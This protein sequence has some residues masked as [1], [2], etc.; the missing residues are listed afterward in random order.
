MTLGEF[1]ARLEGVKRSGNGRYMALCPAHDD[2]E[3]SLSIAEKDGKVLL[4]CHAGCRTEDVLKAL[5]LTMGDLFTDE[6]ARPKREERRIVAVYRYTDAK[7]KPFEV[8]KTDPKGFYQRQPDGKGGYV[9]N[10]KG[11][12]PTLYHQDELPQAIAN[13][14]IIFKMEG[15]EDVDNGRSRL[16]LAATTNPMGAGKWRDSYTQALKGGDL[17]IIP[18]KDGRGRE[19]AAKV[20]RS[21]YGVAKRVRTLELPDRDGYKVKDMSDWLAA[22]GTREELERLVGQVPDYRP[23]QLEEILSR[24]RE[25]YYMPDVGPVEIV[26]GNVAANLHEGDPVWLLLVAPPG[27]G[28]TEATNLLIG[29]EHVHAVAVLT[30]ASLLSGTPRRQSV[31]AKGGLL[32]ELDDFGI[33]VVKDFGGI[34]SL[35]RDARGPILAA[36]REVYDGSWTRYVGSDGGRTLHW[37]GKVG[38]VGGATPSIDQHYAVMAALGERFLYYRL[39]ET[40]EGQKAQAALDHAGH[41]AE[42]RRD[43]ARMVADFF[44]NLRLSPPEPLSNKEQDKLIALALF[45]TRC[46]SAVERDSWASREIQLVPGTESPTRLVKCL[47]QLLNGLLA[48]GVS[49]KRAWEL[50]P[51]VALDSIPRSGTASLRR[52]WRATAIPLLRT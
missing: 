4:H 46:R 31:G 17:V 32:R 26:R 52:C 44:A 6:A 23:A 40:D 8:V 20:A 41:E 51:K 19:H 48:I 39:P 11:I 43:L 21:C 16:G 14:R 36:L 28:K 12:V 50:V 25:C 47:A 42:M 29:V 24:C 10:L 38:L 33:L 22:G 34:L 18:D 1:L 49:R 45:T 15:E 35:N 30:E 7:G 27:S 37:S 3:P 2:R 13:G 9:N 5:G